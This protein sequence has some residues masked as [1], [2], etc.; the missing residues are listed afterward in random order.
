MNKLQAMMPRISLAVGA[1]LKSSDR[2]MKGLLFSPDSW[3]VNFDYKVFQKFVKKIIVLA[4]DASKQT[5]KAVQE[6]VGQT[7]EKQFKESH[8]SSKDSPHRSC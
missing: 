1:V 6:T 4:N 7:C 2:H 5:V 8:C 3:E